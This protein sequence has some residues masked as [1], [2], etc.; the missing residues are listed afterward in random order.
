[1]N[2]PE[3]II[4]AKTIELNA[5]N[6]M[7]ALTKDSGKREDLTKQKKRLEYQIQIAKIKKLIQAL[8]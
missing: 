3:D 2:T 8:G 1:M 7:I 4:K 6:A 5:K